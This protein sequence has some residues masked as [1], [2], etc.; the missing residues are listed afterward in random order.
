MDE[1]LYMEGRTTGL[2][3]FC[4]YEKAYELAL[5]REKYL[6]IC[7]EEM[8]A[9]FLKGYREGDRRCLYDEAYQDAERGKQSSYS[10][11][12]CL[13]LEGEL[14]EKEYSKGRESFFKKSCSYEKGYDFGVSGKRVL[15][16]CEDSEDFLK[17]W[18]KGSS[19]CFYDYAYKEALMGKT[20]SYYRIYYCQKREDFSGKKEYEKGRKAGLKR[21]CSHLGGYNFGLKGANYQNT[22]PKSVEQSFF[23]G[24]LS[25]IREY[26]KK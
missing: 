1:A 15:S 24:Y 7:P 6:N 3:K 14:S 20:D 18:K 2:K 10:S 26:R 22:C 8:K 11:S 12:S 9:D 16:R 13:K 5:K 25:G 4:I 21:L 17:G 23:K 19:K